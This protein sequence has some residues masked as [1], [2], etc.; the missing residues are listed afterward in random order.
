[1]RGS[2]YTGVP[3]LSPRLVTDTE[4]GRAD[5]V[6]HCEHTWNFAHLALWTQ[7]EQGFRPIHSAGVKKN[8]VNLKKQLHIVNVKNQLHIVN[9]KN[10]NYITP[11]TNILHIYHKLNSEAEIEFLR[12]LLENKYQFKLRFPNQE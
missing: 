2:V 10:N 1:M 8:T 5:A 12:L 7:V 4:R 6:P 11:I 9:L 3:T